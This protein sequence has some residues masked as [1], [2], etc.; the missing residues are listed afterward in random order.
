MISY[1]NERRIFGMCGHPQYDSQFAAVGEDSKILIYDTRYG[2]DMSPLYWAKPLGA[3]NSVK[4]NPIAS[5]QLVTTHEVDGTEVW[6]IRN[7]G[8]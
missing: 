8:K 6:D 4:F 1:Q 7:P 3:F 2:D 5:Y